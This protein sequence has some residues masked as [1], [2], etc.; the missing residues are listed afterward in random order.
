M[1]KKT[2]FLILFLGSIIPSGFAYH[3][4]GLI[5]VKD[6]LYIISGLGGNVSFLVTETGV[7]VVDAGTVK[8]DAD[9]IKKYIKSVTDNPIRY[10]I[11]THYHYDHSGGACGFDKSVIKIAH[12]NT[13]KNLL[14]DG[15]A[16]IDNYA[17]NDIGQKVNVLKCQLD[18]LQKTDTSNLT[19]FENH[20]MKHLAQYNSAKETSII[21]PDLIFNGELQIVLD[22]DTVDLKHFGN[23]HTDGSICV[24]FKNKKV[25]STGDFFFNKHMPSIAWGISD[26][27]NWIEQLNFLAQLDYDYYIPGHGNVGQSQDMLEQAQYLK[28][29]RHEIKELIQKGLT[30]KQIGETVR[31][32]KYS[33]YDYQFMLHCEINAVYNELINNK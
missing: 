27:K 2:L 7:I 3:G 32:E 23:T 28:D 33:H 10:L 16:M 24:I 8:Q 12:S 25:V 30:R 1:I 9:K 18:S 13:Q 29:L 19:D 11:L 21:Q 6:S 26:T 17:K 15:Q 5:K 4:E 20:Y 31:M 14:L 22:N